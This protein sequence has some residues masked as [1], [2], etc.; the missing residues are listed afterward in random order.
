MFGP[1][2][3]LNF[4]VLLRECPGEYLGK[5]IVKERS[6]G[7]LDFLA[8]YAS[9]NSFE[10]CPRREVGLFLVEGQGGCIHVRLIKHKLGVAAGNLEH[11]EAEAPGLSAA[12]LRIHLHGG[13]E[14]LQPR[15]RNLHLHHHHK[16]CCCCLC[17]QRFHLPQQQGHPAECAVAANHALL[18][19]SQGARAAFGFHSRVFK[20]QPLAPPREPE[21][22]AAHLGD[23]E[24]NCLHPRRFNHRGRQTP[25]LQRLCIRNPHRGGGS[26]DGV[27][28]RRLHRRV[29]CWVESVMHGG[30]YKPRQQTAD[31]ET[32]GGVHRELRVNHLDLPRAVV[33]HDASGMK[34]SVAQNTRHLGVFAV[35]ASLERLH[36]G[37]EPRVRPELPRSLG[38]GVALAEHELQLHVS[39]GAVFKLH[40]QALGFER[41]DPVLVR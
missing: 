28:S 22:C 40:G 41:G 19:Q 25:F 36:L 31:V 39:H 6:P 34:V 5:S 16:R 30:E 18:H 4:P 3:L 17:G 9:L 14:S 37:H 7:D 24:P 8:E 38:L 2:L 13:E 11:I 32:R 26:V 33:H 35:V 29:R 23:G 1:R 10:G 15:R 20:L 12:P 27:D 21:G